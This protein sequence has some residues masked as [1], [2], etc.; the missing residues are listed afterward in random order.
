[1]RSTCGRR[2]HR[3]NAAEELEDEVGVAY[4][5]AGSRMTR[6]GCL[7][8]EGMLVRCRSQ[9][10]SGVL[11]AHLASPGSALNLNER[12][13]LEMLSIWQEH[14]RVKYLHPAPTNSLAVFL[15][16]FRRVIGA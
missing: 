4:G 16:V 3:R 11:S 9:K 14:P 15:L 7:V 1:M 13:F 8:I 5:S 6:W 2:Q 10:N 12:Q